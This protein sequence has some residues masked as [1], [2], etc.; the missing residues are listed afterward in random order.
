MNVAISA[1]FLLLLYLPGALFVYAYAYVPGASTDEIPITSPTLTARGVLAL[2]IAGALHA[3]WI[4]LAN[5]VGH[6]FDT[7]SDLSAVL[8]LLLGN[9]QNA[10]QTSHAIQA[11]V[12]WPYCV[13]SYF[14]S[15]Y[16][17]AFILGR[18]A[19]RFVATSG[20]DTI[21]PS[22]IVKREPWFELF[23]GTHLGN[24]ISPDAVY[25]AC[26]AE[27][28]GTA[29]LYVGFLERYEYASKGEL[30]ML[31]LSNTYRRRLDK[32]REQGDAIVEL[33]QDSRF[34]PIDGQFFIL[35]ADEL[36]NINV[37][38]VVLNPVQQNSAASLDQGAAP[39]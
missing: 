13:F 12:A 5:V 16:I 23:E 33:S 15:L 36:T 3:S 25:V 18:A 17:A 27:V 2:I 11:I 24:D 14:L 8:F 32:D 29:Y 28:A 19:H 20:I 38:Y 39:Q 1:F 9:Y 21:L 30:S 35:R 22:L 34:Y 10:T 7:R 31:V 6:F 4:P 37:K 26:A